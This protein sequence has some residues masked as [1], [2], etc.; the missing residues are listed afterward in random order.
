MEYRYSV[1]G[2][3]LVLSLPE[4]V[5]PVGSMEYFRGEGPGGVPPVRYEA[6]WYRDP[7]EQAGTLAERQPG[8]RI[9]QMGRRFRY[10]FNVGSTR[11]PHCC[12]LDQDPEGDTNTLWLP[13]RHRALLQSEGL[14]VTQDLGQELLFLSHDRLLMHA[15]L[16][17]WRGRGILFTGPSG[18]GKSTQAGLW[19]RYLGAEILNGDKAV[20]HLDREIRA[21][22]S[23]YA[24]TSGIYRNEMAIPAGIVS[25]GQG[26]QNEIQP[27]TGREALLEL[28]PRMATAPWAGKWHGRGVDLALDLLERVPVYRLSCRPDRGAVELTRRTLFPGWG[29]DSSGEPRKKEKR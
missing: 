9:F 25:L 24:G 11:N 20:F 19:Q 3:P 14:P 7:P 10:A 4:E 12:F 6:R 21:W 18:M 29:D 17:R 2:I 8:C 16:V 5:R 26:E 27:L 23:P 1:C 15:A 22:G 13:E 28:M